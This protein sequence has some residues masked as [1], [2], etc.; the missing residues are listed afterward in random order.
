MSVTLSAHAKVNLTLEVLGKRPDG[1][2]EIATVLQTISLA[3][4]V[5]MEEAETLELRCDVP[6]LRSNDNLVLKSARLLQRATG[7]RKGAVIDLVK[8]IPLA[9]GLGS[10]STDAAAA[11]AGLNR[12]WG[13]RLPVERLQEVAAEVGSDVP[14]FLHGGTAVAGGRGEKVT[15]LAPVGETWMVLLSPQFG[16]VGN[17]TAKMYSLLEPSHHTSGQLTQEFADNCALGGSVDPGRMFNVFENVAFDFFPGLSSYR[18]LLAEAGAE[19]V[20]L[21]GSGPAL[22]APVRDRRVGQ[23]VLNKLETGGYEAYLVRSV[24]GEPPPSGCD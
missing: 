11:L 24:S 17:K 15:P 4:T 5:A 6:G 14:F 7:C 10:G 22:F 12:L 1:Y 9:A 16:A 20:H 18:S 2:H 8:R 19:C 13:L 3:D 21:A 23:A